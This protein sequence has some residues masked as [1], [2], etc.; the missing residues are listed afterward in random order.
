MMFDFE[1][2]SSYIQSWI[3]NVSQG[4]VKKLYLVQL[5]LFRNIS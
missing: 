5:Y 4:Q 2:I 1:I 3:I